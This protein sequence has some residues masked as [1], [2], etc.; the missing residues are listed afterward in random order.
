MINA[1]QKASLGVI[2]SVAAYGGLL[3]TIQAATSHANQLKAQN[4]AAKK[5]HDLLTSQLQQE[6]TAVG[7][8]QQSLHKIEQQTAQTKHQISVVNQ[9]I[10][11]LKS[12]IQVASTPVQSA[13]TKLVQASIPSVSTS[14]P[15]AVQATT[16]ASGV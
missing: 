4:V 5:E 3:H 7:Q 12:G 16:K 10:K 9:Q 8:L 11:K 13:S 6:Q 14:Q 15:P 1:W 2:V